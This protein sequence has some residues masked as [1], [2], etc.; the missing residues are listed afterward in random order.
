V[1]TGRLMNGVEMLIGTPSYTD[2]G[3]GM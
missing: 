1:A 2:S 3:S